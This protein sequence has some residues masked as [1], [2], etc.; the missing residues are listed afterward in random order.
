MRLSTRTLRS[1]N[2]T[3]KLEGMKICAETM[4][5]LPLTDKFFGTRMTSRGQIY[6]AYS[7]LAR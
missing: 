7:K 6:Q 1:V 2:K 5:L 4:M 3:L